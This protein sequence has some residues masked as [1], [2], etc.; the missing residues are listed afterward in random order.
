MD[1][2]A[3]CKE[4]GHWKNECL[5]CKQPASEPNKIVPGKKT[6]CQSPWN[7]P[8]LPV[9]K[10]EG[11]DYWSVQ[12]LQAVKNT[13]MLHPVVPNPYTPLS[14]LLPQA[15][16]FTCLDL[17]DTFFCL[18]LS[19]VS[20][21]LFAFE[22]E[23]PHTGLQMAWTT[24]LQGFKNSP[25]SFREALAADLSIFPED[26]PSCT[27]LQYVDDLLLASHNWEKCWE[28]M[29]AL[30][31]QFSKAG[32]KVSWKKTQ[33]CQQEVQYLGFIISEG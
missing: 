2:C 10:T 17:K 23:D 21:P 31:A 14:L 33:V 9:K 8:L 20:Q 15:S 19:L 4:I 12:D 18:C 29:K 5:H 7:T 3:Y 27:L 32:Y 11:S 24:L 26:N 22:W 6:N 30:L 25:T 16:W 1:Q 13:I 28:G